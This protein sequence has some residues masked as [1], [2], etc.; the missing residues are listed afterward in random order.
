MRAITA[1]DSAALATLHIKSF[2]KCWNATQFDELIA[3]GAG[4][5]LVEG[6][7]FILT[8]SA[9]DEV[10]ILTLATHPKQRRRGLAEKLVS[11]SISELKK[12]AANVMF[13]E[14]RDDN[15]AAQTLYQKLGF[16]Q[17]A[18]RANYYALPDGTAKDAIIMRLPLALASTIA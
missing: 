14:V 9:A 11:H 10:E 13:L 5:W 18:T 1:S 7:A 15:L 3:S 4:G 17:T 8:R 2:D 16:I 6:S 12:G